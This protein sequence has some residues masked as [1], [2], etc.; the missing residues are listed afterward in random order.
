MVKIG[1]KLVGCPSVIN[2][3]VADLHKNSLKT[4]QKWL[5]NSIKGIKSHENRTKIQGLKGETVEE[6]VKIYGHLI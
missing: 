3:F 1:G 6:S 4:A 5:K 2:W